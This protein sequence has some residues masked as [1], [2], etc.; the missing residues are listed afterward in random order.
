MI[1]PQ[2]IL[3]GAEY[4]FTSAILEV[5]GPVQLKAYFLTGHNEVDIN[6]DY[7]NVK[8][9]LLDNLYRVETLD[10]LTTP[11]VPEDIDILIIAAPEK[12]LLSSEVNT[13]NEYLKSGGRALILVNPDAPKSIEQ[14][15]SL[16]GVRVEEGT[17]I[18][19]SSYLTPSKDTPRVLDDRNFFGL[20]AI[21]FPGATAI[22]PRE[23]KPSTIGLLE[24]AMTSEDSWLEMNFN[25]QEEP[26]FDVGIDL[27]GPLNLGLFLSALPTKEANGEAIDQEKLSRLIILGDSDFASNQ[28][29]YN[30]NNAD[31]FLHSVGLLTA[32]KELVSIDRRILPFRKLVVGPDAQRFINYSSVGLLPLIVLAIG[33]TIWWRRR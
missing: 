25:S 7:S 30:G 21:Y 16:W 15:I 6:A 19:T 4:A 12:P 22:I 28:H 23:E 9:G 27:A 24:L 33:G 10:L 20:P 31:F 13:I 11:S 3:E 2:E 18:D 17:I 29:F 32:G 8:Q 14:L 1:S 26:K 5:T